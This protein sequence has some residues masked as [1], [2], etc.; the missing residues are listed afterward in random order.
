MA[1]QRL[2]SR[3]LQVLQPSNLKRYIFRYSTARDFREELGTAMNWMLV[4]ATGP[5]GFVILR[6]TGILSVY[7]LFVTYQRCT[8]RAKTRTCLIGQMVH[9]F[10]DRYSRTRYQETRT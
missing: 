2:D 5:V 6:G 8:S 10:R 1:T 9:E 3:W 7:R 4:D